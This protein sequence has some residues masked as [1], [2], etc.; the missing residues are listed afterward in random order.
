MVAP[1]GNKIQIKRTSIS[2]RTPNTTTSANGA[3]IDAGE[4]ALNL[5]DGKMFSSNGSVFFE[6]GANV[7]NLNVTSNANITRLVANGTTGSNGQTLFSDGSVL[8]WSD[9][10]S[11][12]SV[13]PLGDYGTLAN[14]NFDAFG[15]SLNVIYDCHAPGAF[16][17][18]NLEF[19]ENIDDGGSF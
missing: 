6:I 4:L 12:V 10:V 2:G 7:T 11:A 1:T 8:Y 3:F 16:T 9:P 15:V 17:I 13:F 19:S 18:V 14:D 5:T